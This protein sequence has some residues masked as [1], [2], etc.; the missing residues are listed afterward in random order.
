MR[1]IALFFVLAMLLVAACACANT[2][3]PVVQT[4]KKVVDTK[5]DNKPFEA[6]VE[7][8][9][10]ASVD[11]Y[12]IVFRIESSGQYPEDTIFFARL[13]YMFEGDK[14]KRVWFQ[15]A[16]G[17]LNNPGTFGVSFGKGQKNPTAWV[18]IFEARA[19]DMQMSRLQLK[20]AKGNNVETLSSKP[21]TLILQ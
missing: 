8:I 9:A 13:N 16:T 1:K 11:G 18:E 20:D 17:S 7:P 15:E 12:D 14:E 21:Q 3:S 5:P 19:N 6:I 10:K 2:N 4:E